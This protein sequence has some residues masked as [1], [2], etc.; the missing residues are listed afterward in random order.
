MRFLIILCLFFT[1]ENYLQAQ[2]SFKDSLETIL[3]K[4]K[5]SENDK[6]RKLLLMSKSTL[7]NSTER[8]L[9]YAQQGLLI[10]EKSN[11]SIGIGDALVQIAK[12]YYSLERYQK[13]LEYFMRSAKFFK[14]KN[15]KKGEAIA[16]RLIGR[17]YHNLGNYQQALAQYQES[18]RLFENVEVKQEIAINLMWIGET[19][20][21]AKNANL[22]KDNYDQALKMATDLQDQLLIAT[23]QTNLGEWYVSRKLYNTS[24]E[25]YKKAEIILRKLPNASRELARNLIGK[26]NVYNLTGYSANEVLVLYLEARKLYENSNYNEGIATSYMGIGDVYML[27]KNYPKAIEHYFKSLKVAKEL[28]SKKIIRDSYQKLA[29]AHEA[30]NNQLFAFQNFKLFKAYHDSLY[31][32]SEVFAF[33]DIQSRLGYDIKDRESKIQKEIIAAKAENEKIENKQRQELER[34][35]RLQFMINVVS[36]LMLILAGGF[37]YVIYKSRKDIRL[38]NEQLRQRN[39]E[40][41]QQKTELETKTE[42]LEEKSNQLERTYIKITDSIRYAETIQQSI[43]P[44]DDKIQQILREYFIISKPKD[45]VS[46]DFYWV[47]KIDKYKFVAVVDCTGHGVSGGLMTMIGHTLLNEIINQQHIYSPAQILNLLNE[48]L[49]NIIERQTENI[50]IGMEVA[51][52]RF[53]QLEQ[54]VQ[55]VYA[56]AK[57]PLWIVEKRENELELIEIT[58]TSESIGF[59]GSR[60]KYYQ[61][62]ELNLKIG[63]NIY[64]ASDGYADQ[65][66]PKKKRIGSTQLKELLRN[67]AY[68][69]LADQKNMLEKT[70]NDHQQ[71]ATQRDDITLMGIKI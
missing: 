58:G 14:D 62:Q 43:L 28:N 50:A 68:L 2:Q 45:V 25:Y 35:V 41:Q 40:V 24:L 20:F 23:C 3:S 52:C 21:S 60:E 56:G 55:L 63:S 64:L 13:A 46:G 71:T 9:L 70:L 27:T 69:S 22:A 7:D 39:L 49:G 36:V 37:L 1:I 54:S 67:S 30:N 6:V 17:T 38:R 26:A 10:A 61:N 57:R 65:A 12:C 19:Y 34:N 16:V 29:Q 18:I 51:L 53:E 8:A 32:E 15:N 31:N 44:P 59:A 48:G 47:A 33:S 4:D 66:N 42:L 5:S 11:F